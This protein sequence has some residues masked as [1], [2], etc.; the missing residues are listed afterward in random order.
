MASLPR[1]LTIALRTQ[2]DYFGERYERSQL[3]FNGDRNHCFEFLS[4]YRLRVRAEGHH[5]GL[6]P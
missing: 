2:I 4:P 6:Q 5:V 3:I 1:I